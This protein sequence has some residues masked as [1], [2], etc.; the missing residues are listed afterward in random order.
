MDDLEEAYEENERL[1][2]E[3]EE[4]RDALHKIADGEWEESMDSQFNDVFTTRTINPTQIAN[5]AL[6]A[7]GQEGEGNQCR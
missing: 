1:R 3:L 7:L 6:A 5:E 4:A 2:K